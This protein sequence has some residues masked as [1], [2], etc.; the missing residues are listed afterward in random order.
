MR[1]YNI[2]KKLCQLWLATFST[3]DAAMKKFSTI[4]RTPY[5]HKLLLYSIGDNLWHH[6]LHTVYFFG[7]HRL[8]SQKE[9]IQDF[10]DNNINQRQKRIL[11]LTNQKQKQSQRHHPSWVCN[12]TN[13]PLQT[14]VLP[15]IFMGYIHLPAAQSTVSKH[16][17]QPTISIRI[18]LSL[19]NLQIGQFTFS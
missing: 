7:S 6:Q 8:D 9:D 5:T 12:P 3:H 13:T 14:A 10:Q 1:C 2:W 19:A 4:I 17:S 15:H 18:T 16:N 11:I